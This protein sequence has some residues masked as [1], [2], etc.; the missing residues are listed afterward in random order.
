[1]CMQRFWLFD[2]SGILST[3]RVL[4]ALDYSCQGSEFSWVSLLYFCLTQTWVLLKSKGGLIFS[5][6]VSSS[7]RPRQFPQKWPVSFHSMS[8]SLSLFISPSLSL[9]CRVCVCVCVCVRA[10]ARTCGGGE[11]REGKIFFEN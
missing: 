8:L 2:V 10:R 4:S 9:S 6:G 3:D 7:K 11:G 5:S 1:V